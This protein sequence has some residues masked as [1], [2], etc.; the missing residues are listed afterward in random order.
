[1]VIKIDPLFLIHESSQP[2][3]FQG[4]ENQLAYDWRERCIAKYITFPHSFNTSSQKGRTTEWLTDSDAVCQAFGEL[5]TT[6][7]FSCH[8]WDILRGAT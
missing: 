6:S 1:M 5:A 7:I 8:K 4:T 2:L 3:R